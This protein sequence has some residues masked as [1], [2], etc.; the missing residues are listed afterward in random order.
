MPPPPRIRTSIPGAAKRSIFSQ[1]QSGVGGRGLP[2]VSPVRMSIT[3]A[4]LPT[5]QHPL[6]AFQHDAG[7]VT[8][9]RSATKGSV[10]VEKEDTLGVLWELG[11]KTS[12][13]YAKWK[14][15]VGAATPARPTSRSLTY[16]ET[17]TLYHLL[18]DQLLEAYTASPEKNEDDDAF[19]ELTVLMAFHSAMDLLAGNERFLRASAAFAKH[20]ELAFPHP[21][22][23]EAAIVHTPFVDRVLGRRRTPGM[24]SGSRP[25]FLKAR[26]TS[27]FG[28]LESR[29][30]D[31]A[32][33]RARRLLRSIGPHFEVL[34]RTDLRAL[35]VNLG[36][37]GAD[38]RCEV[39][40]LG[41]TSSGSSR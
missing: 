15:A 27:L 6:T 20:P 39:S 13:G 34:G 9:A 33:A 41:T 3:P 17:N 23:L 11:T 37:D 2:S 14:G 26:E 18:V 35:L 21:M 1:R 19:G 40:Y 36:W 16:S 4:V 10:H 38:H 28:L 31:K 5:S 25:A 24:S 8:A 12:D 32:M 30:T 29:P 7:I 22:D